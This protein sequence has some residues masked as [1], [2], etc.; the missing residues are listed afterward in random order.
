M[1]VQAANDLEKN[2][3]NGEKE[4]VMDYLD[5]ILD[6]VDSESKYL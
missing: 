1:K 4:I 2:K 5:S 3:K 6:L